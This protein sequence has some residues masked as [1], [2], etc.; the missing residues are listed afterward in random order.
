MAEVVIDLSDAL[1]QL[2]EQAAAALDETV[3]PWVVGELR[4]EWP[5]D[6]GRSAESWRFDGQNLVNSAPYTEFIRHGGGLAT[7]TVLE[8]II[9][10]A[11]SRTW[12]TE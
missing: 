9:D 7:E 11:V 4:S 5:R 8:S 1:A 2:D 6:T 3:M 12:V 10:R